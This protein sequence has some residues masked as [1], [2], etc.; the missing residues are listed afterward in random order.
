[1][2]YFYKTWRVNIL[3]IIISSMIPII[4]YNQY[5]NLN[6]F[7]FSS[8]SGATDVIVDIENM[9]ANLSTQLDAM[10]EYQ[11]N[12]GW[13]LSNKQL[14]SNFNRTTFCTARCQKRCVVD[15]PL[16]YLSRNCSW[17][18]WYDLLRCSMFCYLRMWP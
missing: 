9:L 11:L 12:E 2:F 8:S 15:S 14:H 16:G 3:N 17:L 1:M 10:L 5:L 7:P 13:S 18:Q 4:A 6:V